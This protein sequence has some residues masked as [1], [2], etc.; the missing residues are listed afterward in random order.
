[1]IPYDRLTTAFTAVVA[2]SLAAA[3]VPVLPQLFDRDDGRALAAIAPVP[4]P[5]PLDLTPLKRLA[6]FGHPAGEGAGDAAT[7]GLALRGIILAKPASDSVA[8][9][10]VGS[11]PAHGYAAGAVLPGGVTVDSI[12]FDL[13]V[14]R[15]GG[16]LV[17]LGLPGMDRPGGMTKVAAAPPPASLEPLEPPPEPDQLNL[18]GSLGATVTPGGYLIGGQMPQAAR[19]AGLEPGDVVER[20]SGQAVGD[21]VRDRRLFDDAVV[22][23]HMQVDVMRHGKRVALTL[24]LN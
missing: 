15:V 12:E 5:V 19:R 11:G 14:L 2:L 16:S 7:L 23:G 22:A 1:M 21:P 9:I 4:P 13:V 18:L 3:A 24:T 20:V 8:M 10:A 17:T 6:P